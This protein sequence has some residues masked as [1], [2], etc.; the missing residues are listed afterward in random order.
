MAQRPP[1]ANGTIVFVLIAR[2][3]RVWRSA[4]SLTKQSSLAEIPIRDVVG[5]TQQTER[6]LTDFQMFREI[7][8]RGR[9]HIRIWQILYLGDVS[10]FRLRIFAQQM[11]RSSFLPSQHR[12]VQLPEREKVRRRLENLSH[13]LSCA[14]EAILELNENSGQVVEFSGS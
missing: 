1:N 8:R 3:I 9:F 10:L 5:A 11:L 14:A 6:L 13:R 12:I 2:S 7:H 4:V